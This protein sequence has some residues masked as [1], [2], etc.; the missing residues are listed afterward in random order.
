MKQNFQNTKAVIGKTPL[1]VLG[2]FCTLHSICLNIGFW[3]E[4]FVLGPFC[5][6]HSICLNIGFWPE[7]FV[8]SILYSP[9]YLS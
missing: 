6:L 5:T 1:F 8:R 7:R 4:R 3:R 9:F 2:P